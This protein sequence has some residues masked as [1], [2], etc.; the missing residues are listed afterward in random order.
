MDLAILSG[1]RVQAAFG[2]DGGQPGELGQNLVRRL[3]G[4]VEVLQGCD[5]TRLEAGEAVT[6]ITPT[7]G[8]WGRARPA[9][10]TSGS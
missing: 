8:G 9:V 6:V 1:R 7:G 10:K 4:S 3:N 5:Q 2:V